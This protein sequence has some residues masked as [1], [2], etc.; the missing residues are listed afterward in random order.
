MLTE[1]ICD[2]RK[3]ERQRRRRAVARDDIAID[4]CTALG[5]RCAAFG[6]ILLKSGIA[7]SLF[8]LQQSSLC[9]HESRGGAN[10][11]NASAGLDMR[12]QSIVESSVAMQILCAGQT[13]GE[14][15]PVGV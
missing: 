10:G 12:E 1:S 8:A 5:V 11:G 15:K 7:C 6:Q 3:C 9:K 13:T 14:N 2:N 4:D